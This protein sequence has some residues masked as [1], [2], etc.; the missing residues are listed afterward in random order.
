MNFR[1]DVDDASLVEVTQRFFTNIGNIAGDFF[2]P[3]LGIARRNFEFIDMD[4]GGSD[5]GFEVRGRYYFN[6]DIAVTGQ[7]DLAK[8]IETFRIGVRFEF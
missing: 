8:D 3:K 7:L 1:T 5:T 4:L 2:R 6:E